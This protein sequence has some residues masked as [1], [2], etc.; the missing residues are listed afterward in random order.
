MHAHLFILNISNISKYTRY[1]IVTV[2]PQIRKALENI[3]NT[4]DT[5]HTNDM[6]KRAYKNN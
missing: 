5:A 2:E 4:A 3:A 1:G 6:S